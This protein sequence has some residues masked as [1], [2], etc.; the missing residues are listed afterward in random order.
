MTIVKPA[1]AKKDFELSE[2][3]LA[4]ERLAGMAEGLV[5][6]DVQGRVEGAGVRTLEMVTNMLNRK[7][8]PLAEIS[9][10]SGMKEDEVL[11]LRAGLG[12]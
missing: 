10:I 8:V 6:G 9:A 12:L 11:S 7:T 5:Q 2:I 1:K 3:V 4:S